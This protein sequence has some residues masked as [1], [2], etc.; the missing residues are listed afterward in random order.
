[1]SKIFL[2]KEG[3]FR[4]TKK[5]RLDKRFREPIELTPEEIDFL[6][7]KTEKALK[8]HNEFVKTL[9]LGEWKEDKEE[10]IFIENLLKKLSEV[11]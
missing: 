7:N 1:M 4:I 5:E 6:K 2:V 8:K 10:R 3:S 9:P 11:S